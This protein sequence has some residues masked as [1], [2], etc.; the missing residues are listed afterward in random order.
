MS[1]IKA[2][3]NKKCH[4]SC[5]WMLHLPTNQIWEFK[6]T[7]LYIM[8]I[9]MK[10]W[11][12]MSILVFIRWQKKDMTIYKQT[13]EPTQ[14]GF[15]WITSCKIIMSLRPRMRVW[16]YSQTI[17]QSLMSHSAKQAKTN[18]SIIFTT[19]QWNRFKSCKCR[20]SSR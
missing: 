13:R 2:K 20:T 19:V 4:L 15:S 10:E 1:I 18:P 12:I 3:K 6:K 7:K 5:S 9:L 17:L 16:N 14:L 8:L 11:M